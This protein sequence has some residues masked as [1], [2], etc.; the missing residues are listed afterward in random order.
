MIAPCLIINASGR[1]PRFREFPWSA[2]KVDKAT[3]R[4]R[5]CFVTGHISQG[6][7]SRARLRAES[8]EVRGRTW[9]PQQV[10]VRV[11]RN[12][13]ND[14][15]MS[16]SPVSR[17]ERGWCIHSERTDSAKAQAWLHP[18]H[19][20]SIYP[21]HHSGMGGGGWWCH[22]LH[23][24]R[25]KADPISVNPVKLHTAITVMPNICQ[26]SPPF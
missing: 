8:G 10:R 21:A 4:T 18:A 22:I 3:N 20:F 25:W 19:I 16:L 2:S 9:W 11:P 14:A 24:H 1:A 12:F 17:L 6:G 7:G 5:V 15:Q 26:G 13:W 23:P